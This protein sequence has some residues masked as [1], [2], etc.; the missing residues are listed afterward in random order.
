MKVFISPLCVI[1]ALLMCLNSNAQDII[2]TISGEINNQKTP[3]D[4]IAVENL[5]NQTHIGFGNLP[6]RDDYRINLSRDEYWGS[7]SVNDMFNQSGL[8]IIKNLP[9]NL[10]V[11]YRGHKTLN[12]NISLHNNKGQRLAFKENQLLENGSLVEAEIGNAG[13]YFLTISSPEETRSFKATGMLAAGNMSIA[14]QSGAPIP[15]KSGQA[16]TLAA[17]TEKGDNV[18]VSVFKLGYVAQLVELTVNG[19]ETLVFPL[20]AQTPPEVQTLEASNILSNSATLNGNVMSEGNS[21]LI[22]R[23]FYWSATNEN[24]GVADNKIVVEGTTGSFSAELSG[25]EHAT[26]YYVR[27][28]A[29]NKIGISYGEQ[30]SFKTEWPRDTQTTVVDVTNP[31]TGKTWMDRNLGASRAAITST[32]IEAYGDLYQWGRAADGH[33]KHNSDTTSIFSSTSNPR[34]G[35]FI[36]ELNSPY[37]WLSPQNTKLWQGVNGTNNPCPN[38]YRLPTLAELDDER[39]SWSTNNADGA[40]ASPLKLTMAGSRWVFNGEL[41]YVGSSGF[42]LSSTVVGANSKGLGFSSRLAY[43]SNGGRGNGNSVRCIKD[44]ETSVSLPTVTTTII[45]NITP[46]IATSGGNVTFNGGTIFTFR[47]VCWNT[48]G[49]PSIFD[50]KT[51]NGTD[52]GSWVSELVELQ[53]NTTYYVRAYATNSKG[54]AYGEEVV[55]TT[56]NTGGGDDEKDIQTALVDVTNPATGKTW[57]DRNLGATRAATSSTDEQAYGDLYQWGRAADGHQKRNSPTTST[58]S[59]SYTSGHGSF[60]LAPSIPWDWHSPQNTNL[61]QGVNGVNNPCP[62]AY[63]LPTDAEWNVE[64]LSWSSNNADGAFASPLKLTIAGIRII[65][66]GALDAVDSQGCYWASTVYDLNS[67]SLFFSSS[68]VNLHYFTSRAYGLSVRCIKD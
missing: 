11:G 60:I 23:G 25:L 1:L 48:T 59:N 36:L 42:Y 53:P 62:S 5:T 57:M 35:N 50:N 9:G 63:R 44:S 34:H 30:I 61:W 49:N 33:Q 27:A 17:G 6:E 68:N 10:V 54:T 15:L 58:L 14:T 65:P 55:F 19:N 24:P 13:I 12:A 56:T 45:T 32:D 29:I 18:K 66:S 31:A 39:L 41:S 40:F 2:Y 38:G 51:E 21:P 8:Q 28:Y 22:E 26:T 20:E 3:L 64:R 67:W 43:T 47:G 37:D 52:T 46:T 4:S 16:Y 7:T